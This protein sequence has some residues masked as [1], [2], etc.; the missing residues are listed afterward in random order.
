VLFPFFEVTILKEENPSVLTEDSVC[1]I[2]KGIEQVSTGLNPF[3][4]HPK[5]STV[6]R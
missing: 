1:F 5:L 2:R 4:P 3:Q 6:E